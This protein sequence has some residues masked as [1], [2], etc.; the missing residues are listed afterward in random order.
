[1]NVPTDSKV[2]S[3]TVNAR[4]PLPKPDAGH[5]RTFELMVLGQAH[6]LAIVRW[7]ITRLAWALGLHSDDID[8]IEIA[9]DEACANVLDH[10]YPDRT[11]KPPLHMEICVSDTYFVVEVIDQGRVFD[12]KAYCPPRFPDHWINGHERGVGLFLIRQF[13]DDVQYTSTPDGQN[14]LRLIKRIQPPTDRAHRSLPTTSKPN[15]V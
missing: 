15:P 6:S 13:M 5:T 10:A 3:A 8:E 2:A 1:M 9:V 7:V 12:Y 11:P 14:R 4:P